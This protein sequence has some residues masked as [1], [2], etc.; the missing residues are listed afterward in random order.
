[1]IKWESILWKLIQKGINII[2]S[3]AVMFLNDYTFLEII[4]YV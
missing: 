2:L 3:N 1:M 4:V